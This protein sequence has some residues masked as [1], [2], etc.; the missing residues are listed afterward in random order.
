M[1]H[2]PLD[3]AVLN[4]RAVGDILMPYNPPA[5]PD[6][7]EVLGVLKIRETTVDGY[8][9]VLYFTKSDYGNHITEV[10]QVYGSNSTFLPFHLVCKL[11]KKFLGDKELSFVELFKS[12]RKIYCWTV[13]TDRDGKPIQSPFK[14][15]LH[16]R[17][18]QGWHYSALEPS[19]VNFY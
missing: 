3:A 10:F 5:A 8:E 7:E 14:I 4:M 6:S 11:A 15:K 19:D 16:D 17:D 18:Y 12:N 2:E 1:Y 9:V 13:N